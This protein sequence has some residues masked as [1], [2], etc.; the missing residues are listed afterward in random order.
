MRTPVSTTVC[1]RLLVPRFPVT[2]FLILLTVLRLRI[3]SRLRGKEPTPPP[4]DPGSYNMNAV[5][6]M[7]ALGAR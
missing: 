1:L 6:P 2:P 4:R 7:I 3:I 5:N